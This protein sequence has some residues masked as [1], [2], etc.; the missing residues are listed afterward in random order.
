MSSRTD[1]EWE[2]MSP[3]ERL[4]SLPSEL[5]RRSGRLDGEELTDAGEGSTIETPSND[6][7][8]SAPLQD[9][10]GADVDEQNETADTGDLTWTEA[11]QENREEAAEATGSFLVRVLD[12][13][14]DWALLLGALVGAGALF[15]YTRPLWTLIS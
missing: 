7:V 13:L 5:D 14:P 2:E 15:A 10:T 3:W 1:E 8:G 4:T 6:Y 11:H 12:A 9:A